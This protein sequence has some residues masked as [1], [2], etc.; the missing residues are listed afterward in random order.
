[1]KMHSYIVRY[2]IAIGGKKIFHKLDGIRFISFYV[3][4]CSIISMHSV[5]GQRLFNKIVFV[6]AGHIYSKPVIAQILQ[7]LAV[8][9]PLQAILFEDSAGSQDEVSFEELFED[10]AALSS[11]EDF[12]EDLF[13]VSRTTLAVYGM[14][15]NHQTPKFIGFISIPGNLLR[16]KRDERRIL[17]SRD[18]PVGASLMINGPM[19]SLLLYIISSL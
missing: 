6:F 1:M 14:N 2:F 18:H 9:S 12:L 16:H 15:I 13:F 11:S 8:F 10:I 5:F 17:S 7:I 3:P 4:I 19:G